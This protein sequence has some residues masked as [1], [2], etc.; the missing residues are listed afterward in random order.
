MAAENN[1]RNQG[2]C[3][4]AAMVVTTAGLAFWWWKSMEYVTTDDARIKAEIVSISSEIQ[5]RIEAL[6]KERR[7][8]EPGRSHCAAGQPRGANPAGAGTGTAGWGPQQTR[9]G[10]KRSDLPY[11]RH[12]GELPQ[13][14]AALAG[15]R[16]N[17][18]DAQALTEKTTAD[19]NRTKS[20]FERQLISA[21]EFAHAD[22]AMRQAEAKLHAVREKIKESGPGTSAD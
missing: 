1:Y 5:G 19:W 12:K 14:E 20:L 22:T 3:G 9:A 13:A 2:A 21:Q 16:H 6:T 7:C 18:E 4:I 8:R 15:H 11:G 10:A 17:L